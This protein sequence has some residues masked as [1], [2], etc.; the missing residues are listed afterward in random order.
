MSEESKKLSK[1]TL[2][3]CATPIGNL[4]DASF[5]LV[6]TLKKVKLIA[7]EDTRTTRK[8]LAH[9]GIGNK[10]LTSYHD[11]S[12]KNKA[13]QIS[14]YLNQGT[15]IALVSESGMPAIQD[16]GYE[17]IKMCIENDLP[18]KVI[19]GPNAALS[20]LVLSG[21][22]TDSFLFLGFLPKSSGKRKAKL[23]EIKNMPYTLIFYESPNRAAG[24]LKDFK[25]IIGDREICLVREMTKIYEEAIRG[26]VT[27][28][29]SV[30]QKKRL[31]GEVVLVSQGCRERLIKK[32][33]TQEIKDRLMFL[34]AEGLSK[35][36][37]MKII[38]LKYDIDRQKLYNISTKI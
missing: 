23:Q 3:I 20:A 15:D 10:K 12:S 37:A 7:A 6:D 32:F 25:D 31:K 16:P 8:L 14:D 18:V 30:I 4:A 34:L 28:V 19:P 13:G 38:R 33:T 24:F 27:H 11:F 22:P 29:L 35:R 21:L 9:Y 1:G 26:K 2:F 17:L 36:E 5:R